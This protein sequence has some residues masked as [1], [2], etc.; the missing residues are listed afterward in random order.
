MAKTVRIC[1]THL[2]AADVINGI[3]FANLG[4]VRVSE[5]VSHEQAEP[6]LKNAAL[7]SVYQG[8]TPDDAIEHALDAARMTKVAAI[9]RQQDDARQRL[10]E[11]RAALRNVQSENTSLRQ[12]VEELEKRPSDTALKAAFDELSA[13]YIKLEKVAATRATAISEL[14]A[15]VAAAAAPP[16]A[17]AAKAK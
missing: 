5:R 12:H 15:K 11:T 9:T 1:T 4:D 14:E 7:F 13:R 16:A 2:N 6:L 8:T 3:T 17:P 10:E